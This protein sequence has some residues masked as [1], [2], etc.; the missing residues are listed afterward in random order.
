V[1]GSSCGPVYSRRSVPAS[2]LPVTCNVSTSRPARD[3]NPQTWVRIG[4]TGQYW[5]VN[6]PKEFATYGVVR[7]LCNLIFVPWLGRCSSTWPPY[8][9]QEEAF[10]IRNDLAPGA[11]RDWPLVPVSGGRGIAADP[12]R[13]PACTGGCDRVGHPDGEAA[14]LMASRTAIWSCSDRSRPRPCVGWGHPQNPSCPRDQGSKHAPRD[15][16]T[17]WSAASQAPSALG[18]TPALPGDG[19]GRRLRRSRGRR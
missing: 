15:P 1:V 10:W 12:C 19:P 6:C 14:A 18:P 16:G 9:D 2:C 4:K 5:L 7:D 17:G 3:I 8:C 13:T 11:R